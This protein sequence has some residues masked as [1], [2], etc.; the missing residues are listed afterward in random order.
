MTEKLKKMLL[1][2]AEEAAKGTSMDAPKLQLLAS[3]IQTELKTAGADGPGE[4]ETFR[5]SIRTEVDALIEQVRAVQKAGLAMRGGQILIPGGRKARQEMLA[6]GRAFMSD[7]QA[8]RFGAFMAC[9][10]HPDLACTRAKEISKEFKDAFA[11][12]AAGDMDPAITTAG[13]SLVP[14]EFRAE[15]IRN[16]ETMGVVFPE[17][18]RVP[19]FTLG[20]TTWPTRT[21]G[22]TA[23]PTAAGAKILRTSPTIG[24]ATLTPVKWATLTGVPN[25][26]FRTNLLVSLG[27]WL[28]VEIVYALYTAL[29]NAVVNGDG[30]ADYGGITGILQSATIASVTPVDDHDAGSELTAIDVSQIPGELPVAY[31]LP[32]AR[33]FLSLSMKG[34]LRNLRDTNGNP[35]YDRA[36]GREPASIDGYPYVLSTHYPAKANVGAAAKWATFG[37]LRMA[38]MFGM[39]QDIAIDTSRDAGFESD[40][41]LVRGLTHVDA[42]EIDANAVVNGITHS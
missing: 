1:A 24:T 18:R 8:E 16:V 35:L 9:A 17:M 40:T 7:E 26:F 32:N 21:G 41:T 19:L 6:D 33:W 15:L 27:Q 42:K 12:R 34:H 4:A 11:V 14:A 20:Q 25:E 37:D 31:A 38:Y 36:N 29:D 3:E 13:G 23:Y 39:L 28:A 5:K 22:L 10:L 30:T 2:V